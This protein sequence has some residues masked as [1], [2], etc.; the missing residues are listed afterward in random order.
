MQTTASANGVAKKTPAKKAEHGKAQSPT[1][2]V[3]VN[4]QFKKM[5]EFQQTID[6]LGELKKLSDDY[7]RISETLNGL[8]EF[9]SSSDQSIQFVLHDCTNKNEFSTYNSVLIRMVLETLITKLK[10]KQDEIV[11]AIVNFKI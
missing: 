11:E 4:N 1:A 7:S 8:M 3:P 5:V 9:K 2:S 10:E 6:K